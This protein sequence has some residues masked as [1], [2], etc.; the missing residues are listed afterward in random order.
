MT[1]DFTPKPRSSQLLLVAVVTVCA[2][3]SGW[4]VGKLRQVRVEPAHMNPDPIAL[5]PATRGELLFGVYCVSCHGPEGQGDGPSAVT[6]RPPPRDFAA[7]PWRF[8]VTRESIRKVTLDG[9]PGTAMAANRTL[10][11]ADVDALVEYVY[12]LAVSR[13]TVVHE[14]TEEESLLRAAGFIDMRGTEPPALVVA[15][16]AGKEVKLS[17]LKGKAVMLHFWG[18][19][20][21]HCVKELPHLKELEKSLAG[22]KF[23]VLHI[24]ADADDLHDAQKLV[25]RFAPGLRVYTD[26]T[27][28]GSARFEVQTLPTVWLIAPDGKAIGRAHGMKDWTSPAMRKLIEHAW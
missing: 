10:P 15:D 24:S 12:H 6:L 21:V 22:R 18:T 26:A 16:M 13:K 4:V 23:T 9:I 2:V 3:G 17:D 20:C 28:L 25:D 27:G 19:S 11:P 14:P 7:R 1:A 8:A 5:P